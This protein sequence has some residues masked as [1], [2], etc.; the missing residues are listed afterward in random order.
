VIVIHVPFPLSAIERFQVHL[1]AGKKTELG[2]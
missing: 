2:D 1:E